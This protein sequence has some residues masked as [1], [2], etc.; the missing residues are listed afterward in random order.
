[1]SAERHKVLVARF[2][3]ELWNR[4]DT[5]IADELFAREYVRHDFRPGTPPPGPEGQKVIALAFRSAFPDFR[6]EVDF[7]VA[8]ES[9]V[10]ARWAIHGTH[11]GAW[12]GVEATGR[13]VSFFGVN[14]F[15][16]DQ[17]KVVELWNHRDDLGLMQ[18]MG[19]SV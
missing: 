4:G 16:F 3:D 19:A 18:Q 12:G 6:L 17:D 13:P 7:M 11:R 8:D 10:V 14:I 9:Y 1:M 2:Y 5:R 15:R